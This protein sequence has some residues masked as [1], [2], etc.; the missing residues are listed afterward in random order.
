MRAIVTILLLGAALWRAGIDWQATIGQGY[1]YRFGTLGGLIS[2]HWPKNYAAFVQGL[3][4]SGL[5]YAW[6]PVGAVLMSLPIALVLAAIAATLWVT[7]E[8]GRSR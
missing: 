1:A 8:R 4:R 6:N 7:R 5:P 3:E 2:A